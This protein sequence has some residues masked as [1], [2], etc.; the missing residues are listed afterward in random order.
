MWTSQNY[1]IDT[2]ALWAHVSMLAAVFA[3]VSKVKVGHGIGG[4]DIPALFRDFGIVV[5]NAVD[6]QVLQ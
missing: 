2:M 3:D 6:T 1:I 5:V 4:G